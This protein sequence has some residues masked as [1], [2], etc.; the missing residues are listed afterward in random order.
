DGHGDRLLRVDDLDAARESVRRLH[1][2]RTDAVVAE[3]LLHL[4]DQLAG[5]VLGRNLD[6]K[7]VVDLGQP[8][9]EDGIEHDALDL[10]DLSRVLAVLVGHCVS[11][12]V[13]SDAA[14][15]LAK[16]LPQAFGEATFSTCSCEGQRPA[17]ASTSRASASTTGS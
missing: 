10:D 11:P 12:D 4:R 16:C 13:R 8:V 2:D 5:A 6:A 17:G 14:R 9:R 15:T 3:V 1:R 7:S